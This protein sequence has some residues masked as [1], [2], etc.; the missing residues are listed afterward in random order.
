MEKE[1]CFQSNYMIAANWVSEH[2]FLLLLTKF[3]KDAI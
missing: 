1:I 2:I 3:Y